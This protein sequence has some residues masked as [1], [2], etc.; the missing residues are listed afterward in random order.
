MNRNRCKTR[1]SL[2]KPAVCLTFGL[3]FGAVSFVPAPLTA[4]ASPE[5]AYST[6][7]WAQ[8][9][10]NVLEYDE[11]GD[12]IHEYNPTVIQNQIDYKEYKDDDSEDI[13]QEYYDAA[14]EIYGRSDVSDPDSSDYANSLYS[15][16]NNRKTAE[17]LRKQGDNNVDDGQ[18]RQL[19]YARTE[20][21]LVK[22]AQQLMISYWS[23]TYN[24]EAL[25][26]NKEQAELT[27]SQ[28]RTKAQAGMA[29]QSQVLSA[30]QAVTD[31]E[32]SI[33]SAESSLSQTKEQLCLMLGWS[34]GADVTISQV[35]EPD[36][37]AINAID[38]EA[39]VAKGKENSYALK[40]LNREI[41]NAKGGTTLESLQENLK[42]Q[43]ETVAENIKSSGQKLDIAKSDYEQALASFELE[44]RN[45]DTAERKLAAGVMTQNDYE[46]EKAAYTKA[47][48]TVRTKKL[49]LL[50]AQSD[51]S[52]S[53]N[54]LAS[55][56]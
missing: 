28:T 36:L 15:Y 2:V 10:D 34:Y 35:P 51:Y 31:A 8:L 19:Q 44:Q 1:K 14:D 50:T 48:L 27:L 18:V 55:A 40:I 45:M 7:R 13:A 39:D 46:K 23:Q 52:W 29:T 56:T 30:A 41:S 38:V 11:I 49:A 17:N 33:S 53:V 54:G 12:L 20:Y 6:E 25:K 24:I 32:A 3:A 43:T 22:Q 16:L 42:S 5:F 9:K 4:L 37:A 26:V 47:Q 21:G